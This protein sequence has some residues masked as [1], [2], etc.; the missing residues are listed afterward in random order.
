MPNEGRSP[1]PK[2]LTVADT[3]R[4]VTRL[5]REHSGEIGRI[6]LAPF[7][8]IFLVDGALALVPGFAP[9]LDLL[10]FVVVVIATAMFMV[11]VHRMVLLGRQA[12]ERLPRLIPDNRDWRYLGR[13]V[14]VGIVV[15]L[16]LALPVIV[17]APGLLALPGGLYIFAVLVSLLAIAG[18]LAVGQKLPAAAVDRD[19]S[20][21]DSWT[22][23][24]RALPGLLGVVLVVIA[25]IHIVATGVAALQ[26][27]AEMNDLPVIPPLVLSVAI[28]FAELTLFAM[29]LSVVYKHY[30][31]IDFKV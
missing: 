30:S 7:T 1:A 31:G 6:A 27:A 20:I 10:G 2:G 25:P 17:F 19:V 21:G 29:L 14:M 18:M 11:D 16:G 8:A 4:E 12:S 3:A 5:L 24:K 22:K 13:S 9:L 23:T 15:A 26:V 28:Q